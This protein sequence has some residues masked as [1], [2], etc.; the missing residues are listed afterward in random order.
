MYQRKSPIG[1]GIYLNEGS[2]VLMGFPSALVTDRFWESG[3]EF[4]SYLEGEG[5]GIGI[6]QRSTPMG[7][8]A[9]GEE[10]VL[11]F[12]LDQIENH[13]LDN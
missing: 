8:Y 7:Y 5:L 2:H 12:F 9:L 13:F 6:E 3:H 10:D 4:K 11:H 1:L